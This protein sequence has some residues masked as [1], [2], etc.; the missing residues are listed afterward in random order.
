MARDYARTKTRKQSTFASVALT[1]TM[2][3]FEIGLADSDRGH[4]VDLDLRV[5]QHPSET[6][7]NVVARVIARALEDDEGVE[8]T[9]GICVGDEPA[10][11]QRNL[12]GEL[13]AWIEV[14]HPS[15]ERLHKA[16]KACRRVA[17]Y[18]WRRVD[19]LAEEIRA[20]KVH[21]FETLELWAFDEAW[22]DEIAAKVDRRNK[23]TLS[24]SG[25]VIYLDLGNA[26]L[27]T[28]VRKVSLV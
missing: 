14:G 16:Q 10:M 3:R 25:G 11:W 28:E 2:R 18:A 8:L 1:A 7:R 21:R 12:R 27:Q 23:W 20:A 5:P 13:E 19:A 22:L 9:S 4:Y 26:H 15:T 6:E 17:V 24:K